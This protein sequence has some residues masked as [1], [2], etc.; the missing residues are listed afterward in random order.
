MKIV[1][2]LLAAGRPRAAFR[3]LAG[4]WERIE[5]ASL[6]RLLMN[7]V[8]AGDDETY[9]I[10][11]HH[12]ADA[13]H[14]LDGRSTVP[15]TEMARLEFAFSP[16]L[17]ERGI[18]NLVRQIAE[19]PALFV[20]V[21][22]HAFRRRDGGQDPAAWQIDDGNRRRATASAAH[23]LLQK[24][25]RIPGTDANGSINVDALLRWLTETRHLCASVGRA[26]IGDYSIGKLLSK[27]A[28]DDDGAWPCDAVC[29]ALEAVAS[30]D[31]VQG[32]A[33]GEHNARG[34][35]T[36]SG[37]GGNDE[38][39]LAAQYRSWAR[40]RRVYPFASN[41]LNMIARWYDGDA[42]DEDARATLAKR[43]NTWG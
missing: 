24:V 10:A 16:V 28:P 3:M 32:F 38:R 26:E 11:P 18:P 17:D 40:R 42:K 2:E 37:E 31:V 22:S 14:V 8:S 20:E 9:P 43:L 36:R 5:T 19:S 12:V 15:S 29:Q 25:S 21:L 33:V 6:K 35:F 27:A 41:A 4:Q 39:E 1:E 30:E 34:A 7:L 13:L 23:D